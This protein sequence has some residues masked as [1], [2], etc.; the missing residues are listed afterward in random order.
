MSKMNTFVVMRIEDVRPSTFLWD[1]D[2][3]LITFFKF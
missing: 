3:I 2:Y 1:L